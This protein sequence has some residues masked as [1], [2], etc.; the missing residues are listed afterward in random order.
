M[1][2]FY[3]VE[4]SSYELRKIKPVRKDPFATWASA[5]G[6]MID[7]SGGPIEKKKGLDRANKRQKHGAQILKRRRENGAMNCGGGNRCGKKCECRSVSEVWPV[8]LSSSIDETHRSSRDLSR[9]CIVT[10]RIY[11]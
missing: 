3:S 7:R 9:A 11:S 5:A 8:M 6:N 2:A 10:P 4:E 1:L